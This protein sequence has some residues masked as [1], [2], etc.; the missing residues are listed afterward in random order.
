MK[1]IKSVRSFPASRFGLEYS[2]LVLV[3][4]LTSRLAGLGQEAASQSLATDVHLPKNTVVATIPLGYNP[5]PTAVVVSPDSR[6]VYVASIAGNG[7]APGIVWVINSATN[8]VTST[9]TVGEYPSSLA[10]TP[11]GST[12]YVANAFDGTVSVISTATNSVTETLSVARALYLAASPDGTK[13]YVACSFNHAISIIYTATNHVSNN[14]IQT[15]EVD[16]YLALAPHNKSAYVTNPDN[17][18]AIDLASKLVVGTIPLK[19]TDDLPVFLSISPDGKK[20]FINTRKLVLVVDTS[21]NKIIRKIVMPLRG[22]MVGQTAI[23]PDGKFL[24]EPFAD[25]NAVVMLDT[26]SNQVVGSLINAYYPEAVAVAGNAAYAYVIG[27]T[28]ASEG[29]LYVVDISPQ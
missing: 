11:D 2:L 12:L 24:Y 25:Q 4:I 15:G 8:T 6:S 29:A 27:T 17:V 20:L 21:N 22:G 3:V 18:L 26:V 16:E 1:K 5:P 7:R 9:I 28:E 19:P 13:V 10:V 14:A 23:T